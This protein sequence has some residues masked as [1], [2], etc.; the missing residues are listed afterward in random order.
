ML[1]HHDI[2]TLSNE[3]GEAYENVAW[4]RFQIEGKEEKNRLGRKKNRRAKRAERP[5]GEEG[6]IGG[7]GVPNTAIP[8][9]KLVTTEIPGRK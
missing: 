8:Y 4:T 7:G 2:C 1:V 3:D 9:E 5:S 6:D